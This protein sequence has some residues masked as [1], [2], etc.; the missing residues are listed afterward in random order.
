MDHL[1]DAAF[2]YSKGSVLQD[3]FWPHGTCHG[4]MCQPF[5]SPE[6]CT[7]CQGSARHADPEL[8]VWPHA[9]A[10]TVPYVSGF[11]HDD[12]QSLHRVQR[13]GSCSDAPHSEHQHSGRC[14]R[15]YQIA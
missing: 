9:N 12:P 6:T 10:G 14:Q 4:S 3:T 2:R 7:M 1:E 5:T 11:Q 15:G 8:P 13:R